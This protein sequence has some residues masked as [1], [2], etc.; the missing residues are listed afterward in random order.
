MRNTRGNCSGLASLDTLFKVRIWS[1]QIF[2][3]TRTVCLCVGHTSPRSDEW[4]L[5]SSPTPAFPS[6]PSTQNRANDLQQH[7]VTCFGKQLRPCATHTTA[8]TRFSQKH[9]RCLGSRLVASAAGERGKA[10]VVGDGREGSETGGAWMG[11]GL[12]REDGGSETGGAW[13]GTG[14]GREEGRKDGGE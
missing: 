5:S 14:V 3:V 11:M 1:S 12:G 9:L 6:L 2:A 13:M 10:Y 4:V 8:P 7:Q